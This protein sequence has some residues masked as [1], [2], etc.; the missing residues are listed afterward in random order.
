MASQRGFP[1]LPS[2]LSFPRLGLQSPRLLFTLA[3]MRILAPPHTC[4][5]APQLQFPHLCTRTIMTAEGGKREVLNMSS[6]YYQYRV[7]QSCLVTFTSQPPL[8]PG[9][10]DCSQPACYAGSLCGDSVPSTH[11]GGRRRQSLASLGVGGGE[12]PTPNHSS[13][14]W[15]L[16]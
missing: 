2:P 6:C 1:S 4:C 9:H 7:G 14:G 11:R 15:A 13:G 8:L 3:H 12:A 16:G 5:V 10:D